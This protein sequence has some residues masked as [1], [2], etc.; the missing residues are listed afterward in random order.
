MDDRVGEAI[1]AG[2]VAERGRGVAQQRG[3][4]PAA[5]EDL[6]ALG[7]VDHLLSV[8]A[9]QVPAYDGAGLHGLVMDLIYSFLSKPQV[10]HAAAS[11]RGV[12]TGHRS[13]EQRRRRHPI[14]REPIR[15]T[16]LH[17]DK[18][19]LVTDPLSRPGVRFR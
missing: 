7:R 11:R 4:A 12:H 9:A 15:P 3:P 10:P 1:R 5:A 8:C 2:L 6:E 13:S 17:E 14:P 18:E 19:P 16:F